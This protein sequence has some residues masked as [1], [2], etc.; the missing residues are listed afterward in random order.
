MWA[1]PY[2][3]NCRL[4][5]GIFDKNRKRRLN[6][7]CLIYML[8]LLFWCCLIY[9]RY[10]SNA[11][12]MSKVIIVPVSTWNT[13]N[14]LAGS[15]CLDRRRKADWG[16]VTHHPLAK[17]WWI[18]LRS[19]NKKLVFNVLPTAS[20]FAKNADRASGRN[21]KWHWELII[22]AFYARFACVQ[23][24]AAAFWNC[25]CKSRVTVCNYDV[26]SPCSISSL[27]T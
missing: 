16:R 12:F 20:L 17:W 18:P 2:I 4:L 10:L 11:R 27:C 1:E 15:W 6:R 24:A 7:P 8:M 22:I 3:K 26:F 9:V 19:K 5:N 14:I 13:Y 21:K 23:S 25:K